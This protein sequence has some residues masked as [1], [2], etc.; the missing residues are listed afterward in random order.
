[1]RYQSIIGI[2]KK[3]NR[4]KQFLILLFSNYILPPAEIPQRTNSRR[5]MVLLSRPARCRWRS[6]WRALEMAVRSCARTRVRRRLSSCASSATTFRSPELCCPVGTPASVPCA[7][8]SI[9][10]I[11]CW[12][13]FR[14][15]HKFANFQ[16]TAVLPL[17]IPS[18]IG[19]MPNV[20]VADNQ[21]LLHSLGGVSA[22]QLH[23]AAVEQD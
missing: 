17:S 13:E 7:F 23:R 1:M 19:E 9:A 15:G 6:Q 4:I 21:L 5:W 20:S 2:N 16:L 3:V 12:S 14:S 22:G 18:Q 8:V 11:I 10:N